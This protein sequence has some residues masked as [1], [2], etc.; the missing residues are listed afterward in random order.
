MY[1]VGDEEAVESWRQ[2]TVLIKNPNAI[3]PLP[4]EWFGASAEEYLVNGQISTIFSETF[5]PYMSMTSI[6]RSSQSNHIIEQSI[7]SMIAPI[8]SVFPP[9]IL[10]ILSPYIRIYRCDSIRGLS[11]AVP[12]ADGGKTRKR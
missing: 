5:H 11:N 3:H 6:F 10:K 1:E 9:F 2:G 12:T 7:L 4:N 8:F